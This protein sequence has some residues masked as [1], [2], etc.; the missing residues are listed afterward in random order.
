[1]DI[2]S[3]NEQILPIKRKDIM[4]FNLFRATIRNSN[5]E[6]NYSEYTVQ[7]ED[8]MRIDLVFQKMYDLNPWEVGPYLEN[9]DIILTINN[10]DNP[11]N[12][13]QGMV[14]KYPDLGTFDGFRIEKDEES[15]IKKKSILQKLGKPN[16]Q[17]RVDPRRKGYLDA[18]N[19]L[20]PTVNKK[21]KAP[22]TLNRKSFLIGGL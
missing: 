13:R 19:S 20:P 10:I 11:L 17:T 18:N 22:V 14:L 5:P 2:K 6:A 4:F 3:L 16:K 9:I 7:Q 21:P 12:I 1:M 15:K 8:E